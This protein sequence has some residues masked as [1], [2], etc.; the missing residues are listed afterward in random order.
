[1]SSAAESPQSVLV[2][3]MPQVMLIYEAFLIQHQ[4]RQSD[5]SQQGGWKMALF[6][7]WH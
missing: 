6:T 1:M 2:R 4:S 3:F 5:S 7:I